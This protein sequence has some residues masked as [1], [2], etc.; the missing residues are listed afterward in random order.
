MAGADQKGKTGQCSLN[1]THLIKG[2]S[3]VATGIRKKMVIY[4]DDYQAPDGSCIRD[5]IHVSDLAEDHLV[6]FGLLQ[7]TQESHVLNCGYGKGS[8]VK[9]VIAESQHV[10]GKDLNVTIGP[11][12]AGDISALVSD[13]TRLIRFTG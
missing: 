8:S 5:Y 1:A 12:R 3:E 10:T 2:A 13:P 7:A 4:G 9:E 6:V 11:R